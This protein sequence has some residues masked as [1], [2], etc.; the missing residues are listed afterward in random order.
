MIQKVLRIRIAIGVAAIFLAGG[1]AGAFVG[2]GIEQR[3]IQ[4]NAE[5]DRL[6]Q[7]GMDMLDSRL[8]LSA[9]QIDSLTPLVDD[10]CGELQ[11]I[12]RKNRREVSETL[13]K[14]YVLIK[15]SLNTEQA[16]ILGAME[17]ELARKA[18]ELR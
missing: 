5:I 4:Q 6:P 7:S 10:A 17:A 18:G 9:D 8:D 14:Y 2:A 13:H 1:I 16:E 15:P 12:F 11:Q 3:Q